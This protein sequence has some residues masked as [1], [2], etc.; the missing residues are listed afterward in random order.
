MIAAQLAEKRRIAAAAASAAED[1]SAINAISSRSGQVGAA[2]HGAGGGASDGAC[3][4]MSAIRADTISEIASR[5]EAEMT[6]RRE[7]MSSVEN[8]AR[9][10]SERLLA[11]RDAEEPE[12]LQAAKRALAAGQRL[13]ASHG[14]LGNCAMCS[15]AMQGRDARRLPCGHS[16]HFGCI[17]EFHSKKLHEENDAS[18]PCYTC[19]VASNR[20]IAS[21][22]EE[23]KQ[24]RDADA[25]NAA[26]TAAAIEKAADGKS[27]DL[28]AAAQ[29]KPPLARAART[30][31]P[32]PAAATTSTQPVHAG[33]SCGDRLGPGRRAGSQ[34]R[35][36]GALAALARAAQGD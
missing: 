31:S 24:K 25:A 6:A 19:G 9:R 5:R 13:R 33:E 35:G 22:V 18:L 17:D 14:G 28:E 11:R 7:L 21:V 4:D 8:M 23:R 12:A 36:R 32:A 20:T 16:F 3:I 26:A 30:P 10:E 2:V 1:L 34:R 27:A 29:P 15:L